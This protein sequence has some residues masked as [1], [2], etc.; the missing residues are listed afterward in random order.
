MVPVVFAG[1]RQANYEGSTRVSAGEN[2][3]V[4]CTR[5]SACET[6]W[7][8]T[9]EPLAVPPDG[10]A[11]ALDFE[12][13][14]PADWTRVN[15]SKTWGSDLTWRDTAGKTLAVCPFEFRFRK[16]DWAR[17]R[18]GGRIPAGAATLSVR[19]GTD[20]PN[21][22]PGEDVVFRNVRLEWLPK[23][24]AVPSN[25]APDL[26]PPL[27]RSRFEAPTPDVHVDVRYEIEDASAID[28]TALAVLRAGTEEPVPFVREGNRVTLRPGKPWAAGVNALVIRV[29][30]V[31][32]NETV[33][34]KAFLVGEKTPG[35]VVRLRDDGVTLIDGRPFF[36]IG[37][38][39]I[40]RDRF[41]VW[42]F[43]RALGDLKK[44]GFNF[45]HSYTDFRD[46]EFLR[47]ADK[48]GFKAWTGAYRVDKGDAWLVTTGRYD[49]ATITW[50]IGDDTSMYVKPSE[51]LDRDE[52]AR[53][54][55]GTRLTCQADAI[56]SDQYDDGYFRFMEHTDVFLPEIYPIL[57]D[58]KVFDERCVAVTVRDMRRALDDIA[59]RADVRR[60]HAVWPILQ[61]FHGKMWHRYPTR[62]ETVATTFA[63]L[64]HG[65]KGVTWFHYAGNVEKE[66]GR[67]YSGCYRTQEDWCTMTNLSSRIAE[68]APVLVERDPAQPP[69]PE[70]LEGP[71]EDPLGQPSVTAL[72]KR[73]AGSTYLLAVNAS[74]KPVRARLRVT[75][76]G[77]AGEVLWER[78]RVTASDGA[79]ED[80]FGG[81]GVH[82]YRFEGER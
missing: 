46:P 3:V 8:V 68:L 6:A 56:H 45:A 32:G 54:L 14:S 76:A 64:V 19:L 79:F 20:G 37:I 9:S 44:A 7:C 29:R 13:R 35:P 26:D 80:A 4:S 11:Y 49:R 1:E 28:W 27:V 53:M 81:F 31:H 52:A 57:G 62:E 78:R 10:G 55:D 58:S 51:L 12:V 24:S 67:N 69:A 5:T 38:Y 21:V 73:H 39:G 61:I 75:G 40:K 65:G 60:P 41:N 66:F 2:L 17:F 23:G 16:D 50:Y 74:P 22:R 15:M 48:H 43:D 70:V 72:M 59:K 77:A 30:D 33:S 34:R 82:V 42:D 63:A 47:L 36:P 18:F 71:G 25:I